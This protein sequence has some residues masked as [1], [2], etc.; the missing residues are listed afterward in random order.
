ML[1]LV[2]VLLSALSLRAPLTSI[3]PIAVEIHDEIG[4]SVETISYIGSMGPL[5]LATAAVLTGYV[6]KH[7]P[8]PVLAITA[9]AGL[10]AVLVSRSG[11]WGSATFVVS[12]AGVYLMIGVL[13][14]V[15]PAFIG[16]RY[17]ASTVTR[18]MAL[19]ASLIAV[20]TSVA[21]LV[22]RW[23]VDSVSWRVSSMFWAGVASASALMFVLLWTKDRVSVH[24]E[25]SSA[26][27]ASEPAEFTDT[28]IEN[29]RGTGTQP[30]PARDSIELVVWFGVAAFNAF[31]MFAWLPRLLTEHMGMSPN[32]AAWLL[33]L[34]ALMAV[35]TGLITPV[36]LRDRSRFKTVIAIGLCCFAVGYVCLALASLW[37]VVVGVV[38]GGSGQLLYS[39]GLVR[40]ADIERDARTAGV[41]G[42]VQ[43]VGYAVGAA[44]PVM[45][46][47][48]REL[49]ISWAASCIAFAVLSLC[50]LLL[51][52]G[53]KPYY[54]L[55]LPA[56]SAID[57]RPG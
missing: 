31:A 16:V 3:S 53:S 54:P 11:S 22:A 49:E 38:I 44:G 52:R 39:A 37:S 40:V 21:P 48:L 33:S 25:K 5:L 2:A 41:S 43:G 27:A 15:M 36:I 26:A 35:P 14:A 23:S 10:A 55:R 50:A 20:G 17:N 45:F 51:L 12:S 46:G 32:H 29:R 9:A 4:I 56:D 6:M 57:S 28:V 13:N 7:L 8:V 18:V 1:V 34:Y 19:Y 42:K 24:W 47:Y 30:R